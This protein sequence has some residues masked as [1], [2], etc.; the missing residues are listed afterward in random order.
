MRAGRASLT[1]M[2]QDMTRTPGGR[3]PL[4]LAALAIGLFTVAGIAAAFAVATGHRPDLALEYPVFLTRTA[5]V[6]AP[7]LLL[8]LLNV[9]RRRPWLLGAVLTLLV[10]GYYVFEGLG[11]QSGGDRGGMSISLAL[12]ILASPIVITLA[13]LISALAGRPAPAAARPPS[14]S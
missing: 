5:M 11:S 9:R 3:L 10:W 2:N 12:A 1:A 6:A 7:F 4:A 14:A 13:C 8:A